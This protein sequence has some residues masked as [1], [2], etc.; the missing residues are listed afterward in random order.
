ME[1]VRFVSVHNKRS[2]V[3]STTDGF[4]GVRLQMEEPADWLLVFD[5]LR[6]GIQ[7]Q[8][9][10]ERRIAVVSEPT[11]F[12]TY[13]PRFLDQF[14]IVLTS[15]EATHVS[16]TRIISHP[17]LNWFYGLDTSDPARPSMLS[18]HQLLDMKPPAKT[19]ELSAVLSAKA[20]LPL[21]RRRLEFALRL[22]ARLGD[23][24]D[25]LGRDFQ[26][27]ADKREGIDPYRYH[28][29]LENTTDGHFWTEKLADPLLGWTLPLYCGCRAADQ[30]FPEG[31]FI[32]LDLE[33]DLEGAI[34]Q[35]EQILREDPYDQHLPAIAESRRRIVED[36]ALPAVVARVIKN[37][38][39][40]RSRTLSEPESL[41]T[42]EECKP[43]L[44]HLTDI[45]RRWRRGLVKAVFAK[46]HA[47]EL[48]A[49]NTVQAAPVG[50]KRPGLS[51]S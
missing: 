34:A 50:S 19:K 20:S 41:R 30:Y 39:V 36:Y 27:I 15:F 12:K 37:T 17:C 14:G 40:D 49:R 45:P 18:I 31:A 23:R 24:F 10:K 21:Q 9:P 7:T 5:N 48:G 13:W 8:I 4:Y 26:P 46:R 6:P 35:V 43:V 1:S 25:L 47:H 38:N 42:N 22:K 16:G 11:D 2:V 44:S 29:A 28:L 51:S 3:D 33:G 32:R